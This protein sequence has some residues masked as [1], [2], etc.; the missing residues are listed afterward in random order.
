V[1]LLAKIGRLELFSGLYDQIII[2]A[3][4]LDE[5]EAKPSK[6]TKSRHRRT[7]WCSMINRPDVLPVKEGY[8]SPG[9]LASSSKRGSA[10]SSLQCV[11]NWI[12]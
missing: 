1:I 6:E 12:A 7:S 4:V 8:P 11:G 9:L 5:I 3:S 2:P 10:A